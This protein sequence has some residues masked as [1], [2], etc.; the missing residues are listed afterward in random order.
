MKNIVMIVTLSALL[1]ACDE[2]ER[3]AITA[4]D[5]VSAAPVATA[6]PA[7]S[8]GSVDP[9]ALVSA[10]DMGVMFGELKEGPSTS[11][12]LRNERQCNF[13][14]MAGSW[15]K[16]SVYS[17]ADRWE[18]EKGITNALSPR[19]VGGLGDDAFAVHRGTDAVVYVR[20]GESILELSCSCPAET[21][22]AIARVATTKL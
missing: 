22:E 11:T 10:Q 20:K 12:G 8:A 21:A 1:G 7:A 6:A 3:A 13:T 15:I 19:A 5:V 16:L 17:G 4:P 9:C 18:W 2:R 14:N